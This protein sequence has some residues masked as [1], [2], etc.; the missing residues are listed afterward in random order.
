MPK[1]KHPGYRAYPHGSYWWV[2]RAVE[3]WDWER[4]APAPVQWQPARVDHT[5]YGNRGGWMVTGYEV[6]IDDADIIEV[7]EPLVPPHGV[8]LP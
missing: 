6:P 4:D 8:V 1:P 5:V 3:I 7:G 2:R